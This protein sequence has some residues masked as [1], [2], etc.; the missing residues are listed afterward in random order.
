MDTKT[1]IPDWFNGKVYDKGDVVEN[2]NGVKIELNSIEL[3]LYKHFKEDK[4]A[5]NMYLMDPSS[6][7]ESEFE[8]KKATVWEIFKWFEENNNN[9]FNNLIKG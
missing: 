9:A 1:I 8:E 5:V 6:L 3:S 7:T 4:L 2:P